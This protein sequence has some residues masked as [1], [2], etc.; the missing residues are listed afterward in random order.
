MFRVRMARP[1]MHD[2]LALVL[3]GLGVVILLVLLGVDTL[4]RI[5]RRAIG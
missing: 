5:W 4:W 2:A 1:M 3:G